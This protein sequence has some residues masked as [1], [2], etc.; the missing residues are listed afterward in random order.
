MTMYLNKRYYERKPLIALKEHSWLNEDNGERRRGNDTFRSTVQCGNSL[1][2]SSGAISFSFWPTATTI[3]V[4]RY[5][6]IILGLLD[7]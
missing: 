1:L 6:T 7:M 3:Q 2:I 5:S 4:H